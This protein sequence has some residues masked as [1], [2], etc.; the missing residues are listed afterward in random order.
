[1]QPTL[2][3][4]PSLPRQGPTP[5]FGTCAPRPVAALDPTQPTPQDRVDLDGDHTAW[6]FHEIAGGVVG[7][8]PTG[9]GD[10]TRKV[11][12]ALS[13]IG[14]SAAVV[15]DDIDAMVRFGAATDGA[16]VFDDDEYDYVEPRHFPRHLRALA[17]RAWVDLDQPLDDQVEDAFTIGREMV[18]VHTGLKV[19]D[20]DI[21]A[22]SA[23]PGYQSP[24]LGYVEELVALGED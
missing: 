4:Q 5:I 2:G 23:A 17:S 12:V 18:S 15:R 1:M 6:S 20:A 10:P 24:A 7:V 3:P 8:E 11:L 22:A 16:L 14:G 9:Y 19:T 13:R 21:E